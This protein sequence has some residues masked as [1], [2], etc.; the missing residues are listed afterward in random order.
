MFINRDKNGGNRD[1]RFPEKISYSLSYL[2]VY[3]ALVISS[4][5]A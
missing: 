1:G 4:H 3:L 5:A 2:I